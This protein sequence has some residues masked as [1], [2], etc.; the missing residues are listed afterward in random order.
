MILGA[1]LEVLRG[2]VRTIVSNDFPP[3]IFE[4]HKVGE[5]GE[6]EESR[7]NLFNF[8]EWLG[9]EII[10]N[11]GGDDRNHLAIKKKVS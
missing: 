11:Y 9:Y 2:A 4:S 6:T 10:E 1:E 5:W 3:I 8:L 7:V